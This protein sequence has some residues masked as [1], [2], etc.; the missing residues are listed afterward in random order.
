MRSKNIM[1]LVFAN[2]GDDKLTELT[3][4]RT[5][6]SVPFGCRYRLIDFTLSSIVN[7]GIFKVGVVTKRNYQSLVDHVGNGKA[8]DLA[9]IRGGLCILSPY[10]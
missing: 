2:T 1:A 3:S 8:R 6:G 5:M 4:F 10:G 7:A 9:R